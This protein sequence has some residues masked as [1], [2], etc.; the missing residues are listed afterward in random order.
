MARIVGFHEESG[1]EVYLNLDLVLRIDKNP[2][3]GSLITFVNSEKVAVK[4]EPQ[5][6]ASHAS[7]R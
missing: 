2:E 4:A 5:E 7:E 6:I 3:G 1:D